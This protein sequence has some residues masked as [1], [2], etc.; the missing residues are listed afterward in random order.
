MAGNVTVNVT[1][2]QTCAWNG[3]CQWEEWGKKL[4]DTNYIGVVLA[5]W[6][7]IVI[8]IWTLLLAY[9][10]KGVFSLPFLWYDRTTKA[11]RLR[12]KKE[13]KD[14]I[15][16]AREARKK[17][18]RA[19]N[20]LKLFGGLGA[21]SRG[22]MKETTTAEKVSAE[23]PEKK[24]DEKAN[25][26]KE[27]QVQAPEVSEN[28]M[29][30]LTKD[31]SMTNIKQELLKVNSEIPVFS[32]FDHQIVDSDNKA[33]SV[34]FGSFVLSLTFAASGSRIP[35]DYAD[36]AL[37][38][39]RDF[40]LYSMLGY[41]LLCIV[42][43]VT[44]KIL[45]YK[46]DV[47][48]E[49]LV[50]NLSVAITIT[51]ICVATA[52][53]LRVSLMGYGSQTLPETIGAT[54][55]FFVLGQIAVIIFGGIF[56]LIT[57]YDDQEEAKKGNVAAGIKWAGNLVSLAIISSSPIRKSSELASF[58][59]FFGIGGVFLIIFDQVI[60]RLV[61]PGNLNEEILQNNWGYALIGVAMML[62]T[63]LAVDALLF[64]MPCPGS[65]AFAKYEASFVVQA[66][67]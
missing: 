22:E 40:L 12:I 13:R 8:I 44:T 52:V 3:E 65:E 59:V 4:S 9:S 32:S 57:S 66:E 21:K 25:D 58:G 62:S 53:N 39:L 37:T 28:E 30:S 48:K 5:Q 20:K 27:D 34:S 51:G 60:C 24:V 36:E 45:L 1:A 63:S 23:A 50:G 2:G 55:L 15:I 31:A 16:A 35:L 18:K 49:L 46:V 14:K 41:F 43:V 61:I 11:E 47:R 56:Q 26:K 42:V 19:K 7:N 67:E 54:V 10:T 29:K 64:D 38:S 33:M 17:F 6:S